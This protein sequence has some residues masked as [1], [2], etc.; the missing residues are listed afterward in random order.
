MKNNK[1][2]K[3]VWVSGIY[4]L[5][6]LIL[7][8][9]IIY[10]V[11]WEYK[12]LNTYL[13]MYNCSGNLCT[14]TIEQNDY[15]NRISCE[16]DVCPFIKQIINNHLILEKN[17]VSWIYNYIT[18]EIVNNKYISYRYIGRNMYVVKDSD[19]QYGVI[20]SDG[21]ILVDVKQ[22]Y[23]SDYKDGFISYMVDDLYGV[24]LDNGEI[25]FEPLFDDLILVNNK[26]FAGKKDN[27]YQLY[28]YDNINDNN[29]NKYNFV[30]SVGGLLFVA[31]DNKIDILDSNLNSTLI[32]KLDTFY[33]YKIGQE[34]ASLNIHSDDKNIYFRIYN[35]EMEYTDYIYNIKN[36]KL[37]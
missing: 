26:I 20:D 9:V 11:K 17:N 35:N 28:S 7:Y 29:A 33:E 5:L 24:M 6:L 8:L 15:Y 23:I 13:Y 1:F 21:N 4:I 27:I 18:G 3:I 22:C 31:K 30:Y 14:S 10:K 37:I 16:N 32:I 25:K 19:N 34:R 12:D 36:K 2:W